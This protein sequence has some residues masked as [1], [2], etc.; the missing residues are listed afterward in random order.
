MGKRGCMVLGMG[1]GIRTSWCV[2]ESQIRPSN[3]RAK[4]SG[5]GDA[6]VMGS[7]V[8]VSRGVRKAD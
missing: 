3:P 6:E 7:I 5:P 2:L 4:G 8:T 1:H